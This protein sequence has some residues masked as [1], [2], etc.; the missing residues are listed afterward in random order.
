LCHV[1]SNAF[2]I[3]KNTAV[4]NMLLKMRVTP[5][6]AFSQCLEYPSQ[7]ACPSWTRE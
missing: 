3:S 2:S 1:V 4:V 6:I 7:I 5:Y